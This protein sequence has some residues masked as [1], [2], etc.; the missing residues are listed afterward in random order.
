MAIVSNSAFIFGRATCPCSGGVR[1]TEASHA[2]GGHGKRYQHRYHSQKRHYGSGY[3]NTAAPFRVIYTIRY[4]C[5]TICAMLW[6]THLCF[7]SSCITPQHP[8]RYSDKDVC[9]NDIITPSKSHQSFDAL[10]FH[11]T[12]AGLGK[13][14]TYHLLYPLFSPIK[15]TNRAWAFFRIQKNP[16]SAYRGNGILY[17]RYLRVSQAAI[18]STT[19]RS[20]RT[21]NFTLPSLRANRV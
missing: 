17:K 1:N 3:S 10:F 18:T 7:P 4:A 12:Q 2:F 20:R 8:Q 15:L 11:I 5:Y 14:I 9:Q 16:A 19:L 21:P 6:L 13:I